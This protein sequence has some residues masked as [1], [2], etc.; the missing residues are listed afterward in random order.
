M[1]RIR[2][3]KWP[4]LSRLTWAWLV[5]A[6]GGAGV[7][8]YAGLNA[9][10]RAAAIAM[11]VEAIERLA[12][13]AE[14]PGE[15]RGERMAQAPSPERL[16]PAF[17]VTTASLSDEADAAEAPFSHDDAQS[18]FDEEPYSME[19]GDI[20]A[21]GEPGHF[22]GDPADE[23]VITIDGAPARAPGEKPPSTTIKSA[24]PPTPIAATDQTML[25]KTDYGMAPKIGAGGRRASSYY[26]KPFKQGEAPDVALI[27]GG[28]GLNRALTERAIDDLP[29][30][31]TL[32]FAPYAKDLAFWTKRARE[33]GHEVLLELPMEDRLGAEEVLGPAA[34]MTT[35]SSAENLKRLDWML[36]RFDGFFGV[37]N[38]LGAKFTA[39]A[40][41][42][43]VLREIKNSGLAYFD[44]S[45]ALRHSWHGEDKTATTVNRIINPGFETDR[46]ATLADLEAL[47][48]IAKRD[49][50][51]IG[52]TYANSSTL[53]VIADWAAKVGEREL[54]LA[55][56]SA[57]LSARASEL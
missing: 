39:D 24:A 44:D 4:V 26:A 7:L 36:S 53:D 30:N 11:P 45:G 54:E 19:T 37:T 49:G 50:D 14:R 23:I 28:L 6:C 5:F 31:V 35:R 42:D 25:R 55:P 2:K 8:A 10:K 3:L 20:L 22:P 21:L 34:L 52:K 1:A 9:D 46:S 43:P 17:G 29:A 57:V 41:F 47:E 56:A 48:K 40:A 38:Y 15:S 33:A 27:V 32:A 13:P 16:A 18:G 51:A 12:A